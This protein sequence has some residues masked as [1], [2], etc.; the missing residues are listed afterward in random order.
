MIAPVAAVRAG[1]LTDRSVWHR[2]GD[3]LDSVP[4]TSLPR[5]A[6]AVRRSQRRRPSPNEADR[7]TWISPRLAWRDTT[8]GPFHAVVGG[9]RLGPRTSSATA[10]A[11]ARAPGGRSS[12]PEK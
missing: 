1:W 4:R 5:A 3:G 7:M 6:R 10:V 8:A 12:L 9:S 2:R 11:T